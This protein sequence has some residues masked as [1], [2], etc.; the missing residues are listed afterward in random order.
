MR[1]RPWAQAQCSCSPTP[2][3]RTLKIRLYTERRGGSAHRGG[4]VCECLARHRRS[5]RRS[6]RSAEGPVRCGARKA[7]V[8][9]RA[10]RQARKARGLAARHH[11]ASR[12]MQ[13]ALNADSLRA[14][15]DPPLRRASCDTLQ[16]VTRARVPLEGAEKTE[17][18]A[19]RAGDG[20]PGALRHR[21]QRA[22]DSRSPCSRGCIRNASPAICWARSNAIAASSCAARST[23]SRKPAA[24]CCSISRRKAAASA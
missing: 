5:D 10:D 8:R 22:A 23:R 6:C 7:A 11:R 13:F 12:Q 1:W 18:V 3:P 4:H 14:D 15:I 21:D 9:L 2:A 20:G 16:I 19:F 24:A 17:L